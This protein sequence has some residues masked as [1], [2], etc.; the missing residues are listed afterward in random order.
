MIEFTGSAESDRLFRLV[1]HHARGIAGLI[2][3]I[4]VV[5]I[6]VLGRGESVHL[7][8]ATQ[9]WN[10]V[11]IWLANGERIALRARKEG[12]AYRLVRVH[13]G[14][15]RPLGPI[16]FEMT[17]AAHVLGRFRTALARWARS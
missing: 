1:S 14:G 8:N 5:L 15:F 4:G 12:G 9:G 6:D 17:D 3:P 16:E 13:R 2:A 10:S 7:V 11:N